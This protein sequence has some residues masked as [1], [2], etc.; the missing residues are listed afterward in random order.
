MLWWVPSKLPQTWLQIGQLI[1]CYLSLNYLDIAGYRLFPAR[2]S[3]PYGTLRMNLKFDLSLEMTWGGK[4]TEEWLERT[5]DPLMKR[6]ERLSCSVK[7]PQMIRLLF[8]PWLSTSKYPS[9]TTWAYRLS[10]PCYQTK[11][12]SNPLFSTC[13]SFIIVLFSPY[14]FWPGYLIFFIF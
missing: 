5:R 9:C 1:F 4:I 11:N 8:Q 14:W 10:T 3:A 2:F 13:C 7:L 12:C 6:K